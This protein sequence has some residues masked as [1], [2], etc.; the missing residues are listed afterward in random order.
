MQLSASWVVRASPE[1]LG[2]Y[3]SCNTKWHV[4]FRC[5]QVGY[6]S[7]QPQHFWVLIARGEPGSES[8]PESEPAIRTRETNQQKQ[9]NNHQD[10]FCIDVKILDIIYMSPVFIFELHFLCENETQTGEIS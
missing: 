3:V 1:F 10:M 5:K 8:D 6:E 4:L 9:R 2:A 7:A